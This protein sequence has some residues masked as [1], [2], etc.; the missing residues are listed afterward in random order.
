MAFVRDAQSAERSRS[1]HRE[2]GRLRQQTQEPIS[3]DTAASPTLEELARARDLFEANEPRDLF[4]RAATVLVELSFRGK[5]SLTLAEALAV[6]LQTW[7]RAFYQ[8]RPFDAEH[9]AYIECLLGQ[10]LA[11]LTDLRCRRIT[12]FCDQ[13]ESTVARLFDDFEEVLWP[14]GA[15]KSLHLLASQFFPIWDRSIARAYGLALGRHGTNAGRYVRFMS[16]TKGQ[17]ERLGGSRDPG[18][19]PLK[20]MDEYNYCKYTKGWM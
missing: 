6:L 1:L 12:T 9:F 20:A 19:N 11:T 17:C 5:S 10:N 15:A 13:D 2:A 16:I 18:G 7:N 3:Q 4:Y 14:V 8:Y